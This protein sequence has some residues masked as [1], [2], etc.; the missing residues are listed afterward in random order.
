MGI[1]ALGG[2]L[3]GATDPAA[4]RAVGLAEG[5]AQPLVDLARLLSGHPTYMAEADH[6]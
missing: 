6:Y 5:D 2:L 3:F 1:G 4:V